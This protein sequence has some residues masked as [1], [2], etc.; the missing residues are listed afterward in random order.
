M[1]EPK[2]FAGVLAAR[3]TGP[4]PGGGELPPF[5]FARLGRR[6]WRDRLTGALTEAA[7]PWLL[8][9]ARAFAPVLKLSGVYW[10]TRAADVEAVLG[11]PE[12]FRVPYGPE[13]AE[14]SAS[15]AA[16]PVAGAETPADELNFVLGMDGAAQ[17]RQN[18]IIRRVVL[19]ADA[20]L[21]GRYAKAFA[22]ALIAGGR[23]RLD[24]VGDLAIRVPTEICRRYFG[25][26]VADPDAFAEWAIS[27]S[28]LL[29]ADPFGDIAT[30]ETAMAGAERL[31][32]VIGAAIARAEGV[33]GESAT[34]TVV[35]RLVA[36]STREPE[37]RLGHAEIGA[38]VL[39][40]VVGFI[41]TNGLAGAKMIEELVRRPE[42][43]YA[44]RAA[45][46]AGD[47]AAME[48]VLLEAG[49][50]NPA[51]APGQWRYAPAAAVV[52][53]RTIP[54]GATLMAATASA[55]RDPRRW[56]SPGRFDAD[57]GVDP[58]LIFGHGVHGCLGKQ[59]AIRIIRETFLPLFALPGL[60]P[61]ADRYGRMQRVGYF[62]QRLDLTFDG[63]AARQTPVIAVFPIADAGAAAK[64]REA[65]RELGNPASA[66]VAA[67]LDGAGTIHFASCSV[68]DAGTPERSAWRL[69]V[70]INGD[71]DRAEVIRGYADAVA[72]WL[73]PVVAEATGRTPS[74]L[75]DALTGAA[76]D[77]HFW[78]WGSTG[79]H[80]PG[81]AEFSVAEIAREA[82]LY[83]AVRGQV[84]RVLGERLGQRAF[85]T[86]AAVRREL[87]GAGRT[88]DAAL[89]LD[90]MTV[91]PSRAE[92][93]FARPRPANASWT[94]LGEV[95]RSGLDRRV[96]AIG[97]ATWLAV[98]LASALAFG[99]WRDVPTFGIAWRGALIALLALVLTALVWAATLGG[100]ALAFRRA[101]AREV[102][103]DRAP[104]LAHLAEIAAR[105]DAPTHAQNHI[106]AVTPLKS[107]L[108]RRLSFAFALWGIRQSL[109]WFRS[110]FVVTMGT[111]HYARWF[112]VPGTNTMVFQ[113][114]YDGSWESYLEDFITRAHQGQT[115]AWSNG[116]GFPPS[117]WL[118][119]KGAEDGDRF[120]RW[121]RRQQVATDHWYSRFPA[122][123]TREIR[124]N[125]LIADGLARAR[126]DTAAREWLDLLGSAPQQADEIAFDEI[127]SLVFR[128]IKH[129]YFSAC[130][131]VRLPE[132]GACAWL[133]AL[134]DGE[135]GR[136]L[137]FGANPGRSATFVALSPT[138]LSRFDAPLGERAPGLDLRARFP[139]AFAF[140]M[141]ARGK[142]LRDPPGALAWADTA[143]GT[144]DVADAAVLLYE[145]TPE[146][147]DAAIAAQRDW[148]AAHGGAVVDDAI[149]TVLL[150]RDGAVIAGKGE[151]H[152]HF[153]YR[154][155]ISQP[156]IRGAEQYTPSFNTR[157]LVAPGEF[158][159]GYRNN[160]GFFPP[161][162]AVP[163][164]GDAGDVL[165]V[166]PEAQSF[167]QAD[168]G[169]ADERL[170]M[171]DF[172]R[173]GTFLVIR[174]LAQ[175][176]GGFH[177][178]ASGKA[179]EL[180][181][182]Y[183]AERLA[184]V[185]GADVNGEWVA[186]KIVGRWPDGAPLIGTPRAANQFNGKR[187][188]NDFAYG[189]DDPQGHACPLGAHIRRTNPR[190]SLNPGDPQEEAITNRHRL[191]R[192]GRSYVRTAGSYV[193]EHAPELAAERGMLF[194]AIVGDI[195][196]Q[197]EF[198]QQTW[199]TLPSFHGL[200]DEP[201]PLIADRRQPGAR[202]YTIPTAAGPLTVDGMETFV[203][204][205]GGG[206]FFMP[207]R[208]AIDYL[209]DPV[210]AR[211]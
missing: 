135:L 138:G 157:D 28:A 127:Q 104:G 42:A 8:W 180:C 98:L 52:A 55:L 29:F 3:G 131:P 125:A 86:L 152:E 49:R 176:V 194:M 191:L 39:G 99:P 173:N 91:A 206:Y 44:A 54:A 141:A 167:A 81:T 186:S 1:A 82:R 172:G 209:I 74:S 87:A 201:D 45:G 59:L 188:A 132:G 144:A 182:R 196:R 153:G 204:L 205:R 67:A 102:P 32:A 76:L 10:I 26:A 72:A 101:E 53:G 95:W 100:L 178:F 113:S 19:P 13:M 94:H 137:T 202:R 184:A 175:D 199:T 142:V 160:Q 163:A 198:V 93:A 18:A 33:E 122:L 62:P 65:V 70:E 192:R 16:P 40:L 9:F 161:S 174:Q 2:Y 89:A 66:E 63:P 7:L 147:L 73:T 56:A 179:A 139:V 80:F 187:P 34:L 168:F 68:I 12:T 57:R 36:L 189:R 84:A 146:A 145:P 134:R 60:R 75:F 158:V 169:G 6:G 17:A 110:G 108:V 143:D 22:E 193:S 119:G 190:D 69:L 111:I 106:V 109:R 136:P 14:L 21:A 5:D 103:D 148:L 159:L 96:L 43:W 117:E 85:R 58:A 181:D 128:G 203:E 27:L 114:N 210:V 38:I 112:R 207:S 4:R 121:V 61:A 90:A 177:R 150:D 41:P 116:V 25:L 47:A 195:E 130:V 30:R 11:D 50:L 208:S 133:K 129:G 156:V 126:T 185:T 31:R 155:G 83:E 48:R 149:R 211:S 115:A 97:G 88:D 24:V 77:L 23:G 166:A 35:E 165:P 140:G 171:R 197:F 123:T 37:L 51:L 20:E 79:L 46:Q 107:G 15:A 154:D 162:V 78:P 118:V 151:S 164:A 124:R 120:K 64:V 170:P 105:E 92:L 183:G 71:G 200:T